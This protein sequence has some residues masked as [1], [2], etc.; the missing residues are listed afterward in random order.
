MD[1][2]AI[3]KLWDD[4]WNEGLWAASW[5]KSVDGLSGA[6]AAWKPAAGRHSIWQCLEHCMFWRDVSV[7]RTR[8]GQ[9]PSDEEVARRNFPDIA[10]ASDAAWRDAVARFSAS[11]QRVRAFIAEA[12]SDIS[13]IPSMLA[14][15]CYHMGQINYLRALQSLAPIA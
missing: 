4:A 2:S 9:S 3:L 6:Q 15:D 7:N 10:D 1:R 13:S 11:H 8:G 5:S 14:H 12:N